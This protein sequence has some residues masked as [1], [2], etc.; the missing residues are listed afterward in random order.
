M[1]LR[2]PI[3][4]RAAPGRRFALLLAAG[5]LILLLGLSADPRADAA[6]NYSSTLYLS[7]TTSS[8]LSGSWQ[9][10]TTAPG[11]ANTG[12][13][14]RIPLNGTGYQD[15]QP[16][17]A[18]PLSSSNTPTPINASASTTP[19]GKGWLVDGTGAV[20]FAAG[21]WTFT[22]TVTENWNGTG[23]ASL[24]VGIW[25]V[26]V[27]GG[28][29]ASSTLLLDP[30]TAAS[31]N[32]VTAT[33][34]ASLSFT[35]SLPS[36][37]LASN[38][39]LYIQYFRD[40][41]AA[42]PSSAFPAAGATSRLAKLTTN[43]G[44]ASVAHPSVNA[45]PNVPTLGA[46]AARTN[47][48]PQLSTTY[49]D[50]DG[51]NGT[52]TFQL[53]SDSACN[54]VLQ[55][56]TTSTVAS[57][58]GVNWTPTAV[59]D[60]TYYWRAQS[61][62]SNGNTSGWS[63]TSSFVVDTTS[64]TAPALGSVSARTKNT[65]PTLSATFSDPDGASDT[66][67]LSF[68]LCS[69]SGCGTVLQSGSSAAGLANGANGSWT[70]AALSD[71]TYYFRARAQDAAGNWSTWST[72]SSFVVDTTAPSTPTLSSVGPIVASSPTLSGSFSDPD[73]GDTGTV[74]VQLCSDSLCNTVLGSGAS[75]WQPTGLSDGTYY[76][77]ARAQDTAGNQSAW[78]ARSSFTLDAQAP[79]T[80]SLGAVPAW[81][82]TTPQL[83]ATFSDPDAWDTGTLSFQLC[84]TSAC[85]SVLQSHT[86]ASTAN[87]ATATWIPAAL[88]D[89]T[90]YF[91][92]RAQ[93]SA[94]N[95]SSWSAAGSFDLDS[96]AP[97][98]TFVS[99][100]GGTRTNTLKLTVRFGDSDAA[101]TGTVN[102]QLCSDALC[103]TLVTSGSVT[104]VAAAATATWAPVVNTDG[105]YYWRT[106]AQDQAGNTS[107]WSA[108]RS[109]TLDTTLPAVPALAGPADGAYLAAMPSLT[110]TFADTDAGDTGTIDFQLCSDS[111]CASVV[112]TGTSASGLA[113]GATGSWTPTLGGGGYYWRAAAVDAAGN[114]SAWS[115]SRS[116]AV[117]S[118]PPS[119]PTL[120]GPVDGSRIAVLTALGATYSDPGAPVA[121]AGS[122]VFQLCPTSGC[123]SPV[124]STTVAA[125]LSGG[126]V[127][128]LPTGVSDGT[129]D[130]RTRAEDAA[131]NDSSWST[132][133]RFTLDTTAPT[134][135]SAANPLRTG[136][137]PTLSA[138][139]A[140]PYDPDD[141][142]RINFEV[143]AD[144]GC[145]TVLESGYS[146]TVAAGS[147]ASWQSPALGDGTYYWRM[148]AEDV[149][150]NRSAWSDPAQ[151]V[152]DT[153]APSVP[154]LL[155]PPDSVM[156]A[157]RL[158]ASFTSGD[159]RD[160]GTL[161]FQVCSDPGCA[162]VVATGAST[163]VP[164]GS[165]AAWNVGPLRDGRY[166]WR[167]QAEDDAGN[168]SGWS[169]TQPFNVVHVTLA[170]PSAFVVKV[171]FARIVL[172][173]QPPRSGSRPAGYV[174]FVNGRRAKRLG[175][176][177]HQ[178]VLRPRPGVRLTVALAA[179]DPVGYLGRR[180]R[181]VVLRLPKRR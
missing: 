161:T 117:D 114:V 36:F 20:T 125:P 144:A 150:G 9:L 76:W 98:T 72:A 96:V 111:A 50:S 10:V 102:F 34:S 162:A 137:T 65:T 157:I 132:L 103:G 105:T 25:K 85:T 166:F 107:A 153:S 30:N 124:A 88:A 159:P 12:T 171:R 151:L 120:S 131:G 130:W 92:A 56:N 115:A 63:A 53:C 86:S 89:G 49:S 145:T 69:T 28:A 146:S 58:S 80:P 68:Q 91:R 1:T 95:Q 78:S 73:V 19:T 42:F 84:T 149:V 93:D 14:N 94:A 18:P 33:G 24:A 37:S 4:T 143:C 177:V 64:P 77:E 138:Q 123:S 39:H 3:R 174:V 13:Q 178:V 97:T 108:A 60:G 15:F 57:G 81:T 181:A 158:T 48:T 27:S 169:A 109:V 128:W 141:A 119:V 173:W 167:A 29:I 148:Q 74:T 156:D 122:I 41:T 7:S 26:T 104:S 52:A 100:A 127:T 79:T 140:D 35:A 32:F 134:V 175:P 176:Q 61:T 160:V 118:T 87:G 133:G 44:V 168:L 136:A 126:Q 54:T 59:A 67:T 170:A 142:A 38:E 152:V 40:Q 23:S 45:W 43:D 154:A 16:G 163:M 121:S 2:T 47:V 135:V 70:P 82:N 179:V 106:A 139:V 11:S 71:G 8:L 155:T 46:V 180:T 112:Q 172:R 147:E 22:N 5:V 75:P 6:N 165:A 101:D 31:A 66:G 116:F 99:P 17:F 83:S 129:Y 62:D 55:S 164:A 51:D 110:A 21:T 90:Y 113:V